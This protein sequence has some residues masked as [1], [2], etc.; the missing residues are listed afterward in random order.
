MGGWKLAIAFWIIL[1][2]L[3]MA[4]ELG[5][6]WFWGFGNPLTYLTDEQIGYLLAPN[7]RT[8]R[9]KNRI[10]INQYS[11]RS[12][13]I[14]LLRRDDTFRVLLLGDSIAN[15]GWWT[16]QSQTISALMERELLPKMPG[17]YPGVEVL[18]ASANSWGPRNQLAYVQRFGTFQAQAIVLL[19]NTDDLFA[20]APTAIPVG[21][22]RH[23]PTHK[24]LFALVEAWQRYVLPYQPLPEMAAVYAETGDRVG[25]NLA[26]IDQIRVISV[27]AGSQFLLAITPLRREVEASCR[28][29]ELTARKRLA[30]FVLAAQILYVDFLPIFQSAQKSANLYQ[31]GI[32]LNRLGNQIVSEAIAQLLQKN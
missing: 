28:D 2:A 31:D 7:Q 9:F 18:N 27:N 15:G 8:R 1:I 16:D 20:T 14:S 17:N 26:A 23:Y 24:P 25:L 19:I 11:M 5:L 12:P 30:D 4:V 3:I 6:R 32:H 13:E 10:A 21:R 22:D 29:Y